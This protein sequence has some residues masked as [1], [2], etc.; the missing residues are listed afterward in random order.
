[1]PTP[2]YRCLFVSFRPLRKLTLA[3]VILGLL[4]FSC[5]GPMFAQEA[6]HSPGWV[7]ISVPE[8]RA[9]RVKAYPAER[10]PEPPPETFSS[11]A[12]LA[13]FA[14]RPADFLPAAFPPLV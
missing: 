3:L 7:V 14:H 1:M 11:R 10:E 13:R 5:A 9:L 12:G 2:A 6:N 4:A 8:Y